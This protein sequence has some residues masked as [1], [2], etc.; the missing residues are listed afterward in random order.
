[1]FFFPLRLTGSTSEKHLRLLFRLIH[2]IQHHRHL[3]PIENSRRIRPPHHLARILVVLSTCGKHVRRRSRFELAAANA[4]SSLTVQTPGSPFATITD[5]G[6]RMRL[7]NKAAIITG[8]A[9]GVTRPDAQNQTEEEIKNLGGK[10]I[11]VA[12]D[13][14]KA[15]AAQNLMRKHRKGV[16]QDRFPGE[17]RRYREEVGIRGL[18]ARKPQKHRTST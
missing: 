17:Q 5:N 4:S 9:T 3:I 8:A 14:S 6:C 15:A 11:A 13:V 10:T 1:M 7:Q 12:A 18:S 2:P 16:R